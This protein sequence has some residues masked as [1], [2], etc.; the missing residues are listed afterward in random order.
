MRNI[1][2]KIC[3]GVVLAVTAWR[4]VWPNIYLLSII[5]LLI[6]FLLVW[7]KIFLRFFI[8]VVALILLIWLLIQT[9]PVQNF[10]AGKISNKLSKDLNTTVKI[11]HVDLSL[12]DRMDLDNTLILDQNKD[13][14][15]K[16]GSLKLRITDW[17]FFKQ[18]IELKYIGL[19]DAVI[20]QQRID[21][22]WN[23][24]F[25]IDHFSSPQKSRKQSKKI[26][27]QIQKID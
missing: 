10:I 2:V 6:A 20:N 13:T 26:A 4:F 12:F 17:F 21:S 5:C 11:G 15:L 27:L 24:Q 8:G 23:Y 19:E 9:E 22:L 1:I 14:L 7:P 3:I 16:A 25:I 18:N